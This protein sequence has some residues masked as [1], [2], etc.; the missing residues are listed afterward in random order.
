GGDILMLVYASGAGSGTMR[1]SLRRADFRGRP[2]GEVVVDQSGEAAGLLPNRLLIR[3][4]RIW[5]V[6]LGQMRAASYF[7][8]GKLERILDL[9][10]L[11]ALLPEERGNAEVSGI[12]IGSDGTIV[13]AVP[14]QFRVH[15]IDPGGGVRS[16]GK[17]GSGAGNFAVLGDVA[18]DGEGNIFVCDRQ[19]SVVMVFNRDFRFLRET[20]RISS[21]E[22]LM[23]PGFLA[24]DPGGR[25]YVS[26]VR[27]R[28]VAVFAVAAA[29]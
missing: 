27:N 14:A 24:L 15:A 19:R 6:S 1:W 11:G 21:R 20:N 3:S 16:F 26:Q 18:L 25:L 8:E 4:G 13:F 7:P 2:M 12:D 17:T 9:A 10:A 5:L 23:R 22:W 28:G 29:P